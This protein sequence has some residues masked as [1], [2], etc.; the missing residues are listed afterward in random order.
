MDIEGKER[1]HDGLIIYEIGGQKFELRELKIKKVKKL[2]EDV[3]VI[4]SELQKFLKDKPAEESAETLDPMFIKGIRKTIALVMNYL[5]G[6][7]REN[8]LSANWW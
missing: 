8:K 4:H 1:I 5:F 6:L 2:A 3:F 7:D